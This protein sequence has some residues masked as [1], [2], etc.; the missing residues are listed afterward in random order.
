MFEPKKLSD[1]SLTEPYLTQYKEACADWLNTKSAFLPGKPDEMWAVMVFRATLDFSLPTPKQW[2][3]FG[4]AFP[5]TNP[6][7]A[8][9]QRYMVEVQKVV[10]ISGKA[11]YKTQSCTVPSALF[12]DAKSFTPI[13]AAR[14]LEVELETVS[15]SRS[16][17]EAR[18]LDY[19]AEWLTENVKPL[20][21]SQRLEYEQQELLNKCV[22]NG[23]RI[24]PPA[25]LPLHDF[26]RLAAILLSLG[27]K[28]VGK[29]GDGGGYEYEGDAPE[30]LLTQVKETNL[31]PY[32]PGT[33]QSVPLEV[34]P[35]L[36]ERANLPALGL[37]QPDDKGITQFQRYILEPSAGLGT[38]ARLT[39]AAI[40]ELTLQ[41]Q[42]IFHAV[43]IQ[44]WL[45]R[46]RINGI[47]YQQADF[48]NW[49]PGGYAEGK[50]YH[51][52]LMYPPQ[53]L[54][55]N[56]FHYLDHII[57]AY[58]LLN[59]YGILVAIVPD[60][61]RIADTKKAIEFRQ[62][63]A[64]YG[65]AEHLPLTPFGSRCPFSP[66]LL[67]LNGTLRNR[68]EP[69]MVEKVAATPTADV[70]E[71]NPLWNEDGGEYTHA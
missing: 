41:K 4:P 10:P 32:R 38:L 16:E 20:H 19:V 28:W 33:W 12:H 44:P 37:E 15:A 67:T 2:R 40:T 66:M 64:E 24:M 7:R 17:Q 62:V 48:L 11:G 8:L 14:Q 22:V 46:R 58:K 1:V 65:I 18:A 30:E 57:H 26:Q 55:G 51:R 39:R 52:I 68:A 21:R 63:V 49:K 3:S 69:A 31:Y 61:W 50:L 45:S 42:F 47:S 53:E 43:E 36:L 70:E 27:G 23:N 29:R 34:V 56:T 9:A 60:T 35:L 59:P 6:G 25:D 71:N 54:D 13:G 5:N